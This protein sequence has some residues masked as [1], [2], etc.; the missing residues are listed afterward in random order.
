M[1][2]VAALP[3]ERRDAAPRLALWF[4]EAY[5]PAAAVPELAAHLAANAAEYATA[6]AAEDSGVVH[7]VNVHAGRFIRELGSSLAAG[8]VVTIDYGDTTRGLIQGARRGEFPFRVYGDQAGLRPAAQRSLRRARDAGHD[9]GRELHR[10]RPRRTARPASSVIHFGPERDLV[11]DESARRCSPRPPTTNRSRSS[12]ETPC[13]R[14]WCSGR[15]RADVFTGPLLSP[16][17]LSAREQDVPKARRGLIAP[18]RQR[19]AILSFLNPD[20]IVIN[21]ARRGNEFAPVFLGD[22][23]N[24][25]IF[26]IVTTS[27][28]ESHWRATALT[29]GPFVSAFAR[30]TPPSCRG[31]RHEDPELEI[32]LLRSGARRRLPGENR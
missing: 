27:R 20:E 11:G 1:E 13:S 3:P 8:F 21:C 29:A 10:P 6:L 28:P 30:T 16:L 17:P 4:E 32:G 23:V 9:G 15:G 19:L 18:I 25:I 24:F 26:A 7:Y 14:C 12:W 5:V 2:A 31:E 22:F